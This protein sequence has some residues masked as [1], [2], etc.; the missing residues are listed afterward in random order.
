MYAKLKA[1]IIIIGVS[2]MTDRIPNLWKDGDIE[3]DFL[4]VDFLGIIL[5]VYYANKLLAF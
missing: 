4:T 5:I 1:R 3:N 2:I